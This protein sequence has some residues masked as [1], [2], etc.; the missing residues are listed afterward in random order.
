MREEFEGEFD[1]VQS[2]LSQ[3]F[4]WMQ[5][6]D[7]QH[8]VHQ[9]ILVPLDGSIKAV[10]GVLSVVQDL[11][12]PEG[13]VILLRVIPPSGTKMVGSSFMSGSQ[14]EKREHSRAM[15]Y[16]K[17]FADRQS[18]GPG[19]WRCEVAVSTAV[20]D[21]IV[22]TAAREEVDLIAMYTHDRNGLAKLVKGS[23]TEK[24][25]GRAPSEVRVVRQRELAVEKLRL[26]ARGLRPRELDAV[27]SGASGAGMNTR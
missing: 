12:E 10:D 3:W 17:Y 26:L 8:K 24:V 18:E 5:F 23:I 4:F 13:E 6:A 16:L 11:I 1:P 21:E 25:M 2:A 7:T 9:K 15:G 22:N 14:V 20:A 19:R 27:G